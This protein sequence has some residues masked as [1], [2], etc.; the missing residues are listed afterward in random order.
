[1]IPGG[2]LVTF[3]HFP[4]RTPLLGPLFDHIWPHFDE[5]RA[6][7]WGISPKRVSKTEK[8]QW[9]SVIFPIFS[10]W[11]RW[12]G[13]RTRTTGCTTVTHRVPVLP[14]PRVPPTSATVSMPAGQQCPSGV[15][16]AIPCSPGFYW[17][18]SIL[19]TYPTTR[20]LDTFRTRHFLNPVYWQNSQ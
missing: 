19:H 14:H 13:T 1:M 7:T 15:S 5:N 20:I 4:L 2:V 16:A 10:V 18:Q 17:I 9:I 6:K 3:R 11:T 8:K 12:G